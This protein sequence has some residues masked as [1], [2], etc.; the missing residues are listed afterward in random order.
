MLG[1]VTNRQKPTQDASMH[2]PQMPDEY[3]S[4][5]IACSALRFSSNRTGTRISAVILAQ[6]LHLSC[7]GPS[8]EQGPECA[9]TGHFTA[10][11][12][13]SVP[14]PSV[15][16]RGNSSHTAPPPCSSSSA[17]P[18]WRHLYLAGTTACQCRGIEQPEQA[19]VVPDFPAYIFRNYQYVLSRATWL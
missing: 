2:L 13:T 19:V 7:R 4:A 6:S 9:R 11:P 17:L 16:L 1:I 18:C 15:F 5:T 10:C 8:D 3:L 14:R 12:R